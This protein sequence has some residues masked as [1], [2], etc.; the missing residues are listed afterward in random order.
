MEPLKAN[1]KGLNEFSK[2]TWPDKIELLYYS[3]H[4]M[5]HVGHDLHRDHGLGKLEALARPLGVEHRLALD[6]DVSVSVSLHCDQ[7][8]MDASE[9]GRQPWLVYGLFRTNKGYSQVVA[10][11]DTI[12]TLIGF[13]GL[14][15]I[16]LSL[17]RG[18][19]ITARMHRPRT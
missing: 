9:L 12:F 1:V 4:I 17:L 14:Y 10:A 19:F 8:R 3:F 13:V 11:G 18:R 7:P 16:S 15:F 6:L 5:P 2:D